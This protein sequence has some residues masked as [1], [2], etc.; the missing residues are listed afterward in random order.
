MEDPVE[1]RLTVRDHGA[2]DEDKLK[3]DRKGGKGVGR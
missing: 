3:F 2:G 1:L